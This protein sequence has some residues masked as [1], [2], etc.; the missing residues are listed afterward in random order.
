MLADA[1]VKMGGEAPFQSDLLSPK[2][3][4]CFVELHI[5]QGP[6]LEALDREVGIVSGIVGID[7]VEINISGK[8]NHSVQ[9]R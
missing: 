5:E 1:I 7:R 6:L 9:P 2:S 3:G 8:Q 4:N